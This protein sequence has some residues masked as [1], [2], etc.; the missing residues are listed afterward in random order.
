MGAYILNLT[1]GNPALASVGTNVTQRP[2]T[3]KPLFGDRI[4]AKTGA[5]AA[6]EPARQ[7]KYVSPIDCAA[8]RHGQHLVDRDALFSRVVRLTS[9]SAA[10]QATTIALCVLIATTGE[11]GQ[12]TV[13]FGYAFLAGAA[14]NAGV[15]LSFH[16]PSSITRLVIYAATFLYLV[17]NQTADAVI[18]DST[19]ALNLL[20][21][22]ILAYMV[23]SFVAFA[24]K[25]HLRNFTAER[26]LVRRGRALADANA[27]LR[28]QQI[29]TRKL[30][31]VAQL[32]NDSVVMSDPNG[33]IIWV[34]DT[35]TRITGYTVAEAIGKKPGDLL[36][37]PE[38]SA[39]TIDKIAQAVAGG[40][41]LRTEVL[42]KTKSGARVWMDINLV[43]VLD[44]NGSVNVVI[45]IERDITTAKKNETELAAAMQNAKAAA[46]AK[47]DFLATMSHEIRTPM[48]AILGMAELLAEAELDAEEQLYATTI[49]ESAEALLAILNDILDLSKLDAGK[50][51]L[52]VSEFDLAT[53]LQSAVDLFGAR[54]RAKGVELTLTLAD[55]M[56]ENPRGDAGRLRQILLNLIGNALK[57]TEQGHVRITAQTRQCQD[58]I[59]LTICVADTGIGIS[60][61]LCGAIFDEFSQAES[62][63]TRQFGGT[64]LGLT[65][66]QQL[67]RQM[68]GEITVKSRLGA[69]SE[70]TLVVDLAPA[71]S[72]EITPDATGQ[73]P[74][75]LDGLNVL[76][77]DDNAANRLLLEKYMN[78]LPI[79]VAFA[80]NGAELVKIAQTH[81]PDV[82]FVDM[83][84]PVMDGL[85]ATR[86]LRALGPPFVQPRII[87]LTANALDGDRRSCLQAGMDDFLTKP[88][89][90]AKFRQCLNDQAA[91]GASD[92]P[93]FALK[94]ARN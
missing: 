45:A 81:A 62:T 78:D 30:A 34:N 77:A 67:A 68:G 94:K 65:I 85:T 42:N 72:A 92:G 19:H 91:R 12:H 16:P 28:A 93:H 21:A 20:G 56:V 83:A 32:A 46:R 64:G 75:N 48:N 10:L 38:T 80:E 14:V 9:A 11:N 22:P 41:L 31:L 25:N 29:E 18:G 61:E 4:A 36:N 5:A 51:S 90:K 7:A 24:R 73:V 2:M 88:I 6:G 26:D 63:T 74:A 15:F 37:A 1:G 23:Y 87:A 60:D 58:Q 27:Q 43:P 50:L 44:E 40:E 86:H 70:F 82:I 3:G 52:D 55:G 84:M 39:E 79:N 57:F 13:F 53:C 17:A 76:V 33:A 59:Q 71:H 49:R 69:G 8:L 47:A 89:A 54:A 66:S 35:F